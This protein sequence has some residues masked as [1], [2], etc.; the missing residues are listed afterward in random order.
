MELTTPTLDYDLRNHRAVY[1]NGGTII[2]KAGNN[3]LTSTVGTYLTDARLFIFSRDVHLAHPER[4]ITAD[5][6]HYETTSGVASFFGTNGRLKIQLSKDGDSTQNSVTHTTRGTYDTK[7]EKARFSKRSDI[8]SKG[9]TLEGD[10]GTTIARPAWARP[11]NVLATDSSGEM[12]VKGDV[13]LY[14]EL[15]ERATITGRSEL[16]M[17]SEKDTLFLHA[18]TLFTAPD[19]SGKRILARRNVRF[20]RTDMQGLCDTLIY[21]EADSMIRMF[22]TNRSCGAVPTNTDRQ[23]HSHN[24]EGWQS[25]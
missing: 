20:F 15:T 5:T 4:T 18:D 21:S 1:T 14:S 22:L 19:S 7:N 6:M 8:L 2:S 11:G 12:I 17:I 16:L 25:R 13:G 10:S 3:T 24:L 23:P 9:R